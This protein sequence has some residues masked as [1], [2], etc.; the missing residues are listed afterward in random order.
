[1]FTKVKGPRRQST[2]VPDAPVVGGY[3]GYAGSRWCGRGQQLFVHLTWLLVFVV[4]A[5]VTIGVFS[6]V[7]RP[8]QIEWDQDG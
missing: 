3:F 5:F 4:F 7:Y 1:M 8:C 2:R 6:P